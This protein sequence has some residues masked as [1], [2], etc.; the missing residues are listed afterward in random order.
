MPISVL[1]FFFFFLLDPVRK[2][3]DLCEL[4]KFSFSLWAE[5]RNSCISSIVFSLPITA[6]HN[7]L[8]LLI[9]YDKWVKFFKVSCSFQWQFSLFWNFGIFTLCTFPRIPSFIFP[10]SLVFLILHTLGTK[11]LSVLFFFRFR[12]WNS[13]Q[14]FKILNS[15]SK[16][17]KVE[18][19]K[20]SRK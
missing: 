3:S 15:C 9:Y 10:S 13:W 20:S 4:V 12:F 6:F 19:G 17:W 7:M 11:V 18:E 1:H 16:L 5:N 8:R 14:S 2:W